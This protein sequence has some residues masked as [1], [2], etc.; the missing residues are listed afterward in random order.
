MSDP[1][2]PDSIQARVQ[3]AIGSGYE[4]VQ[5]IG[6]G[7]MGQVWLAREAALRRL[8]AIKVLHPALGASEVARRRFR[9]E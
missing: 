9:R 2:H 6:S 3:R 7:G 4:L 5:V 8:V 1:V